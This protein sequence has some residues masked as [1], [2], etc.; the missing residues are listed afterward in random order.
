MILRARHMLYNVQFTLGENPYALRQ[1][2]ACLSRLIV[3]LGV[4][5][6]FIWK[7]A[8]RRTTVRAASGIVNYDFQGN[9]KLSLVGL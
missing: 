3:R 5:N 4:G 7:V 9:Y 1:L 8:F 2:L 6:I